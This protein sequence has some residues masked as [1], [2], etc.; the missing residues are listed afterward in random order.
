MDIET[1][2]V[3][4]EKE[5]LEKNEEHALEL[6]QE[7]VVETIE[8]LK[9]EARIAAVETKA[10]AEKEEDSKVF[11]ETTFDTQEV[12]EAQTS[13]EEVELSDD[14]KLSIPR[15][16]VKNL[17]R[18]R[19]VNELR[20][21]N[22]E[23]IKIQKENGENL[24]KR[25]AIKNPISPKLKHFV[26]ENYWRIRGMVNKTIEPKLREEEQKMG[27]LHVTPLLEGSSKGQK[28]SHSFRQFLEFQTAK[29]VLKEFEKVNP[30]KLQKQQK[31]GGDVQ[32]LINKFGST[33]FDT[34]ATAVQI[35]LQTQRIESLKAHFQTHKK[36]LHS[37]RGFVQLIQKRKALLKYLKKK[38][39]S[40]Y[41]RLL[42]TL[43]LRK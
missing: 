14:K 35:A 1:E 25:D 4:E 12:E 33:P 13:S 37:K 26:K 19:K 8:T 18:S 11:A 41:E 31:K 28:R 27:Q 2:T 7:P 23:E 20:I 38:H 39:Y 10:A 3:K 40:E 5:K 34:G 32:E 17:V 42:V 29:Q 30:P 16:E 43:N 36:D 9:E 15:F 24:E 21:L 22:E 6:A